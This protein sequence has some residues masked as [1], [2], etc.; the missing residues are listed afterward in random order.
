MP[1][2][3]VDRKWPI[4]LTILGVVLVAFGG[5]MAI[6]W[7]WTSPSLICSGS[8]V[9]CSPSWPDPRF[10]VPLISIGAVLAFVGVILRG[11]PGRANRRTPAVSVIL[12]VAGSGV[13]E[14]GISAFRMYVFSDNIL[15]Y[16]YVPVLLGSAVVLLT[17]GAGHW[18]TA[19][20]AAA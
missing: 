8:P 9:T 5:S 19:P 16:T 4:A 2:P 7:L 18:W 13:L 11:G 15:L 6:D 3:V 10:P 20:V 14:V 1:L 12:L 17:Y